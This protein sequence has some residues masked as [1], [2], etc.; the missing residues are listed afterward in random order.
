MQVVLTLQLLRPHGRFS[1]LTLL[2]KGAAP[3]TQDMHALLAEDIRAHH[4]RSTCRKG[5]LQAQHGKF[6]KSHAESGSHG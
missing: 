3:V 1:T 6:D 5:T 2:G 4:M